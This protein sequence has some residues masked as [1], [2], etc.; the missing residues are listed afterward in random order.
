[1]KHFSQPAKERLIY[2]LID[3][4]RVASISEFGLGCGIRTQ[5]MI[6][7]ACIHHAPSQIRYAGFDL[8]ESRPSEH[9]ML[10]SGSIVLLESGNVRPEYQSLNYA[11]VC[12]L[13]RR[14]AP[15]RAA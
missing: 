14:S 10:H 9:R 8:F 13:A 5:R 3:R 2:R 15:Y 12:E 6:E 11:Q 1:L 7:L 4:G